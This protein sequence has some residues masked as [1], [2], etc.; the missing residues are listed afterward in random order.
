MQSEDLF[1]EVAA[2]ALQQGSFISSLQLCDK[3]HLSYPAAGQ[4]IRKLISHPRVM[5][6]FKREKCVVNLQQARSMLM[7][8]VIKV[9]AV[10]FGP[11][12]PPKSHFQ[13]SEQR[14]AVLPRRKDDAV[15]EKLRH[16][17]AR[18]PR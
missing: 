1:E 10:P 2:W 16:L 12:K 4:L 3:F 14:G 6:E 18:M 7:V 15:V 9:T 13:T 8:R 11:P 17:V 5:S